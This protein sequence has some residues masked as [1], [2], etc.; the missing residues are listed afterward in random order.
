MC[1]CHVPRGE[2][3]QNLLRTSSASATGLRSGRWYSVLGAA[4]GNFYP[5]GRSKTLSSSSSTYFLS[6]LA[7]NLDFSSSHDYLVFTLSEVLLGL[8]LFFR[9]SIYSVHN[10]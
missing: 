8:I 4:S 6:F 7:K 2:R 3:G 9:C 10:L 1:R 5:T